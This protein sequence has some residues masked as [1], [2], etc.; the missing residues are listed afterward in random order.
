MDPQLVGTLLVKGLKTS[1]PGD[2]K[3]SAGILKIFWQWDENHVTQ[4][5]RACI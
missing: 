4:F 2:N 1:A 5:V 3:I